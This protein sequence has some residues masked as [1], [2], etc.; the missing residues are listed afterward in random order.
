[1]GEACVAIFWP[2]P[3]IKRRRF[4]SSGFSTEGTLIFASAVPHLGWGWGAHEVKYIYIMHNLYNYTIILNCS[5]ADPRAAYV[6]KKE[7]KKKEKEKKK[8]KKEKRWWQKGGRREVEVV[9]VVVGGGVVHSL[10]HKRFRHTHFV[11]MQ[12]RRHEHL[13]RETCTRICLF[14]HRHVPLTATPPLPVPTPDRASL[15]QVR[16][17]Q[18]CR[19]A[20]VPV[21]GC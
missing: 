12:T 19:V 11:H 20:S 9:V 18:A 14:T 17:T 13:H 16:T 21:S 6:T 2:S 15:V 4:V 8:K 5:A 1:M 10:H 7:R 3:G